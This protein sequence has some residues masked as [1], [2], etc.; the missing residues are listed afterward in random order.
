MGAVI[1]RY[2]GDY[3]TKWA[4]KVRNSDV[5]FTPK[6]VDEIKAQIDAFCSL[7][8]T[9]E[10]IDNLKTNFK[11]LPVAYVINNLK[12]WHPN[13]EDI[14]INEPGMQAYND[15]GLAIEAEGTWLDTSLYEIAIL[16]IVSEVWF[17]MKYADKIKY[18]DNEFQRR[19]IEKFSK[20]K[21][22][23]QHIINR[24]HL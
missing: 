24:T 5:F 20:I 19:T 17:K 1:D 9:K 15:C 8:F 3:I 22:L 13:R 23:T 14:H 2:Y 7:T 6:M 10:E 12:N 16:A 18:L 4:L 21:G 11:W